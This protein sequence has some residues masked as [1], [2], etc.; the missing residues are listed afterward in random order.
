[1]SIRSLLPIASTAAFVALGLAMP[2]RAEVA[3]EQ[4][5]LD[6]DGRPFAPTQ[7][8]GRVTVVVVANRNNADAASALGDEV[9]FNLSA[10]PG[11][12]Y[13][14]VL[15][16][17]DVPG[18]AHGLAAGIIKDRAKTAEANLKGRFLQANRSY[19]PLKPVFLPDWDGKIALGL[20]QKSP[21]PE[22]AVFKEDPARASRYVREKLERQQQ[23]LK[24][25]VHVF[26]LGPDGAVRAHL[27]DA[28]AAQPT[29]QTVRALLKDTAKNLPSG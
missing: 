28:G 11:F 7:I 1:M 18:L 22:F 2:L 26:V 23:A 8:Q 21:L 12:A 15:N 16:L 27:L 14:V 17:R 24:D 25:R 3:F 20:W 13:L 10:E 5:G 19:E 29:I 6:L 9:R 4:P